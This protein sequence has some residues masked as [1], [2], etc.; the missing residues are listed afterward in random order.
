MS[1]TI[2]FAYARMNPPT[3]GHERLI[4]KIMN[5]CRSHDGAPYR[6]ALSRKE[7]ND[8]NPLS[9]AKKMEYLAQFFP[10][11]RFT[12]SDDERPSFAEHLLQLSEQG[13]KDLVWVCGSDRAAQYIEF[14]MEYNE[15][16]LHF[17]NFKVVIAG[18]R[19]PRSDNKFVRASASAARKFAR[20]GDLRSLFDIVPYVDNGHVV[21]SLY[22]DLREALGINIY[23]QEDIP[24]EEN[25]ED[26]VEEA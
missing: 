1:K 12:M 6:I 9:P 19:N 20:C 13:F 10:D 11:V 17:D 3:I 4:S 15:K 14:L 7:D 18:E 25:H 26:T 24:N 22:D 5:E 21:V 16:L 23:P 8:K 2:V